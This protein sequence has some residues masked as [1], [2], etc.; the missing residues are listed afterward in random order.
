MNA[1]PLAIAIVLA[2]AIAAG[3]A[4][5]APR[6][7]QPGTDLEVERMLLGSGLQNASGSE[8]AQPVGDYGVWH[9]PQF[10][11]GYPTSATLWPRVIEVRCIERQCEGYALPPELGRTEYLFVRPTPK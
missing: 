3:Y 5:A 8:P 6:E 10:M 7:P 2:V 4:K 11:P 9:V 1:G